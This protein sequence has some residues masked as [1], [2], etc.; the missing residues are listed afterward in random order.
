[1]A[2]LKYIGVI[3][4]FFDSKKIGFIE[5]NQLK[6]EGISKDIFFHKN[7]CSFDPIVF[8]DHEWNPRWEDYSLETYSIDVIFDLREYNGKYKAIHVKPIVE[9]VDYLV[10]NWKRYSNEDRQFFLRKFKSMFCDTKKRQK[11]LNIAEKNISCKI[12][13]LRDFSLSIIDAIKSEEELKRKKKIFSHESRLER[14][15]IENSQY[16]TECKNI[17]DKIFPDFIQSHYSNFDY[18]FSN[19][20]PSH[21]ECYN[22]IATFL[23]TEKIQ[24]KYSYVYTPAHTETR[25]HY[26]WDDVEDYDVYIGE[27]IESRF[28]SHNYFKLKSIVLDMSFQCDGSKD[29]ETAIRNKSQTIVSFYENLR[30]KRA[31]CDKI[32]YEREKKRANLIRNLIRTVQTDFR[33][34]IIDSLTQYFTSQFKHYGP[35]I[36]RSL[37]II[38]DRGRIDDKELSYYA[39]PQLDSQKLQKNLA[40]IN[41]YI[42]H[43][44][45]SFINEN[46]N[47]KVVHIEISA[48][49]SDHIE[50]NGIILSRDKTT[51]YAITNTNISELIIPDSICVLGDGSLSGCPNLKKIKFLGKIKH[52]GNGVFGN[53]EIEGD[54]SQL[55]SLGFNTSSFELT[56]GNQKKSIADWSYIYNKTTIDNTEMEIDKVYETYD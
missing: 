55:Q 36:I 19:E 38:Y 7:D 39:L 20:I 51:L 23:N 56:I 28:Q 13:D 43:L 14:R 9:C 50:E 48:F 37:G 49:P 34:P 45:L 6:K 4:K 18:S 10:A 5:C 25:Y 26:K 27:C 1:M 42:N 46:L 24:I 15:I 41:N 21:Q 32:N 53:A 3:T 54:F 30:N 47:N 31:L 11:I 44:I 17:I 29:Y 8:V 2:N 52:I 35:E 12:D 40:D 16:V 22:A 33:Q